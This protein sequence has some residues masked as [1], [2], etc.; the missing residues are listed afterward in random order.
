MIQQDTMEQIIRS[1]Q[2]QIAGLLETNRSLVESNGK[3]LEQ[4]DALQ[5][6]IQELLSQIAWLNRQLFGRRSEKLAAL[7]PNQLSLFDPVPATGQNENIREEDSSAAVPSKVKPD[8]KKKESRRNRELLEGLPVVEVVIEPDRMDWDRYRRIG[9][10]HTR[11]LEFEPGRLYVKETV[12]PKYGLKDNL[13]L[14]RE[15]ESGVIIAPLPPSPVYKCLAGSTMLA[16]MLLQ[17]Y[18]YHVPFYRQV[19]EFR[20]LGVRLSESILIG[21][22][23]PVYELLRPLYDEL[24]RQIIGY[25]YVQAGGTTVRVISK[26]KADKEY[27]WMLKAVMEKLV[28]FHYDD[29]SRSGQTIRK[30]L[31]DFK[32]YLQSDGYSAYNV[33]EGTEG[34]CLIACLAH[35]RRHFETAL[36]ENRS[37]AEHALKTIQEIYRI[38]HFAVSIR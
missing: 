17:K 19:K 13:S 32:G 23:K 33:F 20:H 15:G 27:L 7:D 14:P 8:G 10:E 25:W 1:Q 29:G 35:I 3:L 22:F 24:V 6:K 21:W 34:V 37:L 16:E 28:I 26:G 2:E 5:R 11:M 36:E 12:R 9:E 31:K 18:E 38:E 4:T 30:L